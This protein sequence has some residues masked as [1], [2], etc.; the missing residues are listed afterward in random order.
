MVVI[1][2]KHLRLLQA[3]DAHG[4]LSGAATALG[5]TQPAVS[6]Q[7]QSLEAALGTPLLV[8]TRNGSRLTEAA[9]VILR[10]AIPILQQVQLAENEALAVAGLRTG[11]VRIAA[12]PSAVP[13]LVASTLAQIASQLPTLSISLTEAEPPKALELVLDGEVDIAVVFQYSTQEK[14]D[15]GGLSWFPLLVEDVHVVLPQGHKLLDQSV[16]SLKS[17]RNDRWIA[18]CPRC[19]GHLLD[20]CRGAGFIPE[21]SFEAEDYVAIQS[22]AVRGLGVAMATDLQ[23]AA[24]SME[25]V[26]SRRLDPRF[27]RL[28]SAVVPRGLAGVPAVRET[29]HTLRALAQSLTAAG[30]VAAPG[31][32]LPL[33]GENMSADVTQSQVPRSS[34]SRAATISD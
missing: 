15:P 6:Q 5:Y 24:F 32:F 7:I 21:I 28:V 1:E 8:R 12:F 10:R 33:W 18:G 19:R 22:L 29:L 11:T 3:V 13:T 30:T 14:P 34:L 27:Q 25:G 31:E 2:I 26:H 20:A 9:E 23:F 16:V 17:L 4:T